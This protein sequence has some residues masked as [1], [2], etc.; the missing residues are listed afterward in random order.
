MEKEGPQS[1]QQREG[2]IEVRE[3]EGENTPR[4]ETEVSDGE[5]KS[6]NNGRDIEE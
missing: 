4:K 6:R 2:E 3:R 5:R 1:G